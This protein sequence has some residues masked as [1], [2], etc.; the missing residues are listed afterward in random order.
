MGDTGGNGL[1]E[2]VFGVSAAGH[3]EGT[4]GD[5]EGL[6]E[7]GGGA[8]DFGEVFRAEDGDGDGIVEDYG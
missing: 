8:V 7:L 1:S 4:Q 6:V 5:G 3:K 2:G